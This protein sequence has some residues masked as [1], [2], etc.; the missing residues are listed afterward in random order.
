MTM[1]C[2]KAATAISIVITAAASV[3]AG[4]SGIELSISP[5]SSVTESNSAIRVDNVPI[6]RDPEFAYASALVEPK[7]FEAMGF[8]FGDSV[9][10]SFSNGFCLTDI[11]YYNGY[12]AKI[13]KPLVCLYPGY[14]YPAIAYSG[15]PS[16]YDEH[17]LS[18]NDTVCISMHEKGKYLT[19]QNSLSLVYSNDREDYSSD[20]EFANFRVM[21][22]GALKNDYLYRSAS[23]CNN[24]Y[25]RAPY[26]SSLMEGEEICHVL[27]LADTEEKTASYC[28]D[29]TYDISYWRNVYENDG[30]C[31]LG[32]NASFFSDEFKSHVADMFRYVI[33][34][35]GPF[36]IHCTEGK[37]R[38]GFVCFV[39]EVLADFSLEELEDD[40]MLTYK[41]YYNI[42]KSEDMRFYK[43]VKEVK[44]DDYIE[45][46]CQ[47]DTI[48]D[49]AEEQL[50]DSV[51]T[52]LISSGL[53][54]DEIA[55]F[56]EKITE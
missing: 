33:N 27:D 42:S 48:E 32:M 24:Q 20:E 12:Y 41:N 6:M 3:L 14:E 36:L 16:L 56:T 31:E 30:V 38:T 2:T 8:E 9:D 13:G 34:E 46:I 4:C 1:L 29:G 15:G 5:S 22:G 28:A 54:E 25:G 19:V 52:Y 53:T 44:F 55:R 26:V 7:D 51:V 21:K 37:D 11:P 18:E 43:A 40:Y 49:L 23:P 50:H 35:D 17:H 45:N 10:I 47:V 39:M